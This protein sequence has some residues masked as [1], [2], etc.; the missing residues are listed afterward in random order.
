MQIVECIGD[1][2]RIDQRPG[3]ITRRGDS[4]LTTRPFAIARTPGASMPPSM[5]MLATCTP[6]SEYSSVR[7]CARTRIMT[8][9]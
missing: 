1:S 3:K 8:R 4:R 2:Y 5:T 7:A 9:G 6:C